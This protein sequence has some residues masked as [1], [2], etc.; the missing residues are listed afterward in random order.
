[1]KTYTIPYKPR[2]LQRQ[3]HNE[4]K[5]FSVLVMHRRFGKTVFA[6]NHALKKALTTP[7][8]NPRVL[9][10]APYRTS[11]KSI[12]WDYLKEYSR[13]VPRAKFN[14]AELRADFPNGARIQLA[15]ADNYEALRGNYYDLV[16][17]DE[18]AQ[19]NPKVWTSVIRPAV[20]DRQGDVIFLGTPSGEDNFFHDLYEHAQETDGW[21]ANMYK[22]SETNLIPE[23]ELQDARRAM[24]Q[25][26]YLQEFE[27]SFGASLVGAIYGDL[28]TEAKDRIGSVPHDR[29]ALVHTA[30]DLGMGDS[31]TIIFWQEV[32]RE[33][34]FINCI[35]DTGQ[36]LDHYVRLLRDY[37]DTYSYNYGTHLFPHDLAVR[38][39]GTGV[40]REETMRSLGVTPKI[41]PRT[42]PNERIHAARSS[43]DRFWF[44]KEKFGDCLKALKQYRYEFDDK[45]KMFRSQ[46]RHDWCSHYAD[47]FGLA[48]EGFRMTRARQK[49]KT[50]DRSWI[51]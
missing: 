51:I 3:L 15:G 27:C 36:G 19:I 21:Y 6:I 18:T 49:M 5:R 41:M 39:L 40:S 4:V 37:Q 31:T 14:E 28:I 33:I 12:A 38:E 16:I 30:W 26:M 13:A 50:Q 2:P 43:F 47:A 20:S 1:M 10:L 29:N 9:F 32:H 11:A 42:G 17:F 8:K 48:C 23:D 22:A 35:E 25:N 44:D 45:R 7:L 34:R 24:D 46:P